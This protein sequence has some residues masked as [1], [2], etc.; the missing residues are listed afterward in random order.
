MQ[1]APMELKE[2]SHDHLRNGKKT[3]AG[4]IPKVNARGYFTVGG[5]PKKDG[6]NADGADC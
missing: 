4:P 1:R 3:G 6:H 5:G 2:P